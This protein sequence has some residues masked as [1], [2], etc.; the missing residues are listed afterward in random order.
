M[1]HEKCVWRVRPPRNTEGIKN[2]ARVQ[3]SSCESPTTTYSEKYITNSPTSWRRVLP[4][5]L[6]GPQLVKKVPEIDISLT[7]TQNL[8]PPFPILSQPNPVHVPTFQ[9]LMFHLN[10]IPPIY[11][12]VFQVVSSLQVSPRK[13]CMDLASLPCMLH[14][15]P[16]SFFSIWSPE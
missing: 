3:W 7:H 8:P 5:M 1:F 11:A 13:P 9:F 15:S 14:A 6:G 4:E 12:L 16:I 10:I 2:P